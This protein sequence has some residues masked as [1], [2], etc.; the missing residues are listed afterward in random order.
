MFLRALDIETG[1]R[2]GEV[3]Q[4]GTADSSTAG[5]VILFGEDSGVGLVPH[6]N[7]HRGDRF[8]TCKRHKR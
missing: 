1:K 4:I 6:P 8:E 5:G 7:P 2:V 3:P